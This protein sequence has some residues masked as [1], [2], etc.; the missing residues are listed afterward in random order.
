M[1]K[2]LLRAFEKSENSIEL[3]NDTIDIVKEQKKLDK[4]IKLVIP[5][6]K[7]MGKIPHNAFAM[8]DFVTDEVNVFMNNLNAVSSSLI[9][10]FIELGLKNELDNAYK[11]YIMHLILHELEHAYQKQLSM[12]ME[13]DD[14]YV[15]I[16]KDFFDKEKNNISYDFYVRYHSLFPAE[17]AADLTSYRIIEKM[18]KDSKYKRLYHYYALRNILISLK[19]YNGN[20]SP[21]LQYAFKT[22]KFALIDELN[23]YLKEMKDLEDRLFYGFDISDKDYRLKDKESRMHLAKLIR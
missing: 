1:E 21:L 16:S 10:E 15:I 5:E 8:Y 22:G 9:N 20:L 13:N 12:S 4:S 6:E 17:R 2:E 14:P 19:D 18:L 7:E 23:P 3:I 11:L